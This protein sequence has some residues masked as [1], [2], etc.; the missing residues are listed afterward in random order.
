MEWVVGEF[1]LIIVVVTF[2]GW[3][4][5]CF[6]SKSPVNFWA[7]DEIKTEEISDIR[8][9][10]NING[11]MWTAF[12]VPQLAAAIIM[13]F[14]SFAATILSTVDIVIGLPVLI[15]VYK[16]VEKKYRKKVK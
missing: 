12:T 9:Y 4:A 3:T 13:P 16:A 2:G 15:L 5:H 11:I 6:L 8:K 7:G 14:N 10:N 1:A